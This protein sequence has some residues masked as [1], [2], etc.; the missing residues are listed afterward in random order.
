[1]NTAVFHFASGHAFFTGLL[2]ITGAAGLSV[3]SNAVTKRLTCVFYLLGAAFVTLSS[4]PVPYWCYGLMIIGSIAWFVSYFVESWKIWCRLGLIATCLLAGAF[5]I[6]FHV[7]RAPSPVQ[8]RSL[9][10]VADSI[11]AGM[12]GSDKS[13]R[14]PSI[15]SRTHHL[16][17]QDLSY[18]GETTSSAL[19]RAL[20]TKIESKLVVV[21]IGG[22]D[23]LGSTSARDFRDALDELLYYLTEGGRQVIMFEL[24]LPPFRN[25]YGRIQRRLAIKHGAILIPKVNL[26][27]ILA[28]EANTVDTVHLTQKGHDAMASQVWSLIEPAY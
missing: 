6:P 13:E 2:L 5:E 15:I 28:P 4:T 10:I 27:S 18:P 20:D 11:T 21:E 17:V 24:P 23:L 12:G 14:W 8:D 26:L 9:T 7:R 22:N 1:M 25:E 19:D 16:E 3:F